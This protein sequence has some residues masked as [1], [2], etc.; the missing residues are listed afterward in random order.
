MIRNKEQFSFVIN[1]TSIY[2]I[3][4]RNQSHCLTFSI[5][6]SPSRHKFNHFKNALA[7]SPRKKYDNVNDIYGLAFEYNL[8]GSRGY[9]IT[10]HKNIAF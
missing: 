9:N 8:K 6:D 7:S 10:I 5:Y 3:E 2:V 4:R 1:D